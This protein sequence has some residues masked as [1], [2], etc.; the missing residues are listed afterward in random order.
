MQET[1]GKVQTAL[2]AISQGPQAPGMD[3]ASWK[4]KPQGYQEKLRQAQSDDEAA[5][6]SV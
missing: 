3:A 4:D 2:E 5:G 6:H 1:L